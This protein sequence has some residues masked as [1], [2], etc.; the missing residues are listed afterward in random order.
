MKYIK[1]IGKIFI[2]LKEKSF[3]EISINPDDLILSFNEDGSPYGI[4]GFVYA[5]Q[6]Y[7]NKQ[8]TY[9]P[10]KLLKE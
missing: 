1:K 3:S 10:T 2:P 5:T 4:C 9:N 6:V 7:V 8:I